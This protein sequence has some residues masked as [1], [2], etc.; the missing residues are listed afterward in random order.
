MPGNVELFRMII[1]RGFNKGD[2]SV[3]DEV[4]SPTL[5]EHQYLAKPHLPGPAILKDQI[6]AARAAPRLGT[7]Y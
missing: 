7:L 3:A 5:I 1:E 4:C 6:E 2:L